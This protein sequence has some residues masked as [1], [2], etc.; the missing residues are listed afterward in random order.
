MEGQIMRNQ[1]VRM[2]AKGSILVC[3]KGGDEPVVGTRAAGSIPENGYV[4][5]E[6]RN[7]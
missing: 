5:K 3:W 2:W 1:C 4:G 7:Q 6:G